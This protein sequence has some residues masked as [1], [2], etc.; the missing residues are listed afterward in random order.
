MKK[1]KKAVEAAPRVVVKA[2]DSESGSGEDRQG[3]QLTEWT[4]TVHLNIPS[5]FVINSNMDMI[6]SIINMKLVN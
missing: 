5:L 4:W 6:I 3:P 2:S 1:K